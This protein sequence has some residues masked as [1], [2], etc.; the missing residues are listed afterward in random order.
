[1]VANIRET[2][3]SDFEKVIG[4]LRQLWPDKE[5]NRNSLLKI[6][7]TCIR[8]PD[9]IYL[10]AEIDGNVIGFCSLVIRENLRVEGLV[11]HIDELIIDE[12]HRRMGFGAEL[13]EAA[14]AAAK[15][16]G[17]KIVELD[18]AFYRQ[19]AHNFYSKEGF[20]KRAYLFSKDMCF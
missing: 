2:E 5:L 4:L 8:S 19:D 13:L 20:E 12:P 14:S 17:C 18:S 3:L 10:C 9:N 1:M 7:S 11:A 15:K 6:F 16:R